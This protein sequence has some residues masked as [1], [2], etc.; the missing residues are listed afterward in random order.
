[1][2]ILEIA[3]GVFLGV[4]LLGLVFG[5]IPE[6]LRQRRI[7]RS[8]ERAIQSPFK[9]AHDQGATDVFSLYDLEKWEREH[10]TRDPLTIAME[11]VS[12]GIR[13]GGS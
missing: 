13:A 1:M 3:A 6:W 10:D 9:R 2:L 12:R 7:E 5:A 4:C 8:Y 11:E